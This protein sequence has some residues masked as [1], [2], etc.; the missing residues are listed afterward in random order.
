MR[1]GP[2]FTPACS[3]LN[4][5][6]AKI[7]TTITVSE[8][9]KARMDKWKTTEQSYDSFLVQILELWNKRA[10]FKS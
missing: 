2:A 7:M 4:M 1:A 10:I 3:E 9:T 6:I 8:I 5:D